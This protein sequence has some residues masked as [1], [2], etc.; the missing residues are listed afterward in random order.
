MGSSDDLIN[1]LIRESDVR[2]RNDALGRPFFMGVR[3]FVSETDPVGKFV[4]DSAFTIERIQKR[5]EDDR[6]CRYCFHCVDGDNAH[7]YNCRK[8]PWKQ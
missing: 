6:F 7:D 5:L 3:I 4:H 1:R 2:D 8:S